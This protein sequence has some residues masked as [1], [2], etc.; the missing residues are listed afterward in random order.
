MKWEENGNVVLVVVGHGCRSSLMARGEEVQGATVVRW[1][2]GGGEAALTARGSSGTTRSFCHGCTTEQR[3]R[4]CYCH[5]RA[6]EQQRIEGPIPWPHDGAAAER[7]VAAMAARRSSEG[8]R[9]LCH[10]RK[11]EQQGNE[12]SGLFMTVSFRSG[13]K[14]RGDGS[15]R[16]FVVVGVTDPCAGPRDSE[17]EEG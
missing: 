12:V 1:H 15:L 11:M 6:K 14:V 4:K 10:G 2:N 9:D 16:L 5:G 13:L 17:E 3:R 7:K 8:E